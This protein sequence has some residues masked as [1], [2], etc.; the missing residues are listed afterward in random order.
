MSNRLNL[1]LL[2]CLQ[3]LSIVNHP[4]DSLLWN[5]VGYISFNKS[6]TFFFIRIGKSSH[7]VSS[8]FINLKLSENILLLTGNDGTL[9]HCQWVEI[10][11]V[12]FAV[13]KTDCYTQLE[14]RDSGHIK[15]SFR[16]VQSSELQSG[17]SA[18]PNG[19]SFSSTKFMFENTFEKFIFSGST[20]KP[21]IC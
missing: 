13:Y 4:A 11:R 1:W 8:F 3:R 18:K 9:N 16:N 7:K 21:N 19:F 6:L 10:A 20:L 17:T 12:I 5:S 2:S 14:A 15:Y